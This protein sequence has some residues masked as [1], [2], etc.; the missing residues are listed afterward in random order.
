M[1]IV[2]TGPIVALLN[3][4]DTWHNWM[5][6]RMSNFI[7]PMQT[8][9]AVLSE[10]SFLL[11]GRGLP[12]K[13]LLQLVER[14]VLEVTPIFVDKQDQHRISTTINKYH[15]L[16]AS[17]A[18]ACLVRLAEKNPQSKILTLDSDFLVYHTAENR[19]PSIISP[20]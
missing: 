16:P 18:D 10:V 3:R 5:L 4:K 15:D 1:I 12:I 14:N 11:L 20:F 6:E 8:C 17:F 13:G 7:E 19:P 2:D 9:E